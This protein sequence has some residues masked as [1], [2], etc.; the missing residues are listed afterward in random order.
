VAAAQATARYAGLIEYGTSAYWRAAAALFLGGF[1]TFACLYCVQPLLPAYV[2]VFHVSPAT[3]SLALSVTTGALAV[4]LA[5]G[6]A[7]ADRWGRKPTMGVSLAVAAVLT[8]VCSASP[9]LSA[10][11]VVRA[12]QGI[13]LAGLPANAIAYLGDEIHPRSAGLAVGLYVSGTTVGGMSGRIVTSLVA[14]LGSWRVA[15]FVLGLLCLLSGLAFWLLL[16]APARR[17][18][19]Q[20]RSVP[21]PAAAWSTTG[22]AAPAS[23]GAHRA[24]LAAR[25]RQALWPFARHLQDSRLVRLYAVAFLLMGTFVP[26]YSYLGFTLLAPPYRL[27]Q[28]AVGWVF[29]L[30]LVGTFSATWMGRQGDRFGAGTVLGVSTLLMLAGIALTLPEHLVAKIG[31]TALATFG[32]FGAHATAS[33]WVAR[34]AAAHRGQASSLYLLFYYL[35]ASA[36]GWAGGIFW[37]RYGWPGAGAMLATLV[38]LALVVAATLASRPGPPG[39]ALRRAR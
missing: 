19:A 18:P 22:A 5:P 12:L 10:L 38:T 3:A 7:A 9:T 11:L 1:V 32:F 37:S 23:T 8:L 27:S 36:G 16:P 26:L 25:V 31:G 20:P 13:V 2:E 14:D 39:A 33:G 30:Y 4:C 6:A 29:L 17:R 15:L 35:G 34:Q 24:R 21:A 28:A